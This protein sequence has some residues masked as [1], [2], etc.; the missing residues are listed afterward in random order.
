MNKTV[1]LQ[2]NFINAAR[3]ENIPVTV[4]LVSGIKL[5]GNIKGFDNFT[6]ILE[7]QGRPWQLVYKH[8]I[9]TIAP[10][11]PIKGLFDLK[12][13]EEASAPAAE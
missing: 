6:L 5:T 12:D 10:S 8:A 7:S 13:E 4:F 9:A 1:N 11:A 2:D 3:K